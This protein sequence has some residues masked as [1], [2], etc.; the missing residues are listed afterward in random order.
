MGTDTIFGGLVEVLKFRYGKLQIL[1]YLEDLRETQ[2]RASV[3]GI[4]VSLDYFRFGNEDEW[5]GSIS[6]TCMALVFC[7]W[8]AV[9]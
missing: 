7:R 6:G 1:L 3:S 4:W 9:S 2:L 5:F 8:V